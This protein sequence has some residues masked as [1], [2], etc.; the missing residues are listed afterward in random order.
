MRSTL[1]E[2]QN[3]FPNSNEFSNLMIFYLIEGS[4]QEYSLYIFDILDHLP[5]FLKLVDRVWEFH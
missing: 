3:I 1:Y 2:I 4:E 5:T